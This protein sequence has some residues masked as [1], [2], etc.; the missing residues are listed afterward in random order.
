MGRGSKSA[1]DLIKII[2]ADFMPALLQVSISVALA[3][4]VE[5]LVGG[6]M[7]ASGLTSFLVTRTQLRSQDGVRV[8]IA[9]KKSH[10]DGSMK[11][12]LRG[13]PIV[14]TLNAVEL[15]A[16][17][18]RREATDLSKIE[19]RHHRTMG[20]FDAGKMT[21]E[22]IFGVGVVLLG[23]YLVI[24]GSSAG[25]VLTLYLLYTQFAAPLREIHRMRDEANEATIH[26]RQ[27]FEILDDPIDPYFVRKAISQNAT[28][29]QIELRDVRVEYSGGIVAAEGVTFKVLQGQ[30]F[31]LC[32]PAGSGKT[33]IMKIIAGLLPRM[34]HDRWMAA[35]TQAGV[36]TARN[37]PPERIPTCDWDAGVSEYAKEKT[38][39]SCGDF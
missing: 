36:P 15:E 4:T 3:A 23:V 39:C 30:F 20:L 33:S 25:T 5:P 2:F 6:I 11:E 27:A 7:L 13:E 19:R 34:E 24:R 9:R 35:R 14:R 10:L 12:L 17:R 8:G 31:G 38:A 37:G 22:S 21:I 1:G 16:S 18:V 28:N 32:G 29:V 26:V